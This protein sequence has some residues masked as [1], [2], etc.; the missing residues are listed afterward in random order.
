VKVVLDTN[1]VVSA[2]LS[3]AGKPAAILQLVLHSNFNI[4]FN[5]AILVEYEQVLYR[6][7]F[8]GRIHQ[9]DIERFFELVHDFGVKIIT[10]PSSTC[11]PDESD[12]IFY[13]T[14]KAGDAI[15]ITGN[16][17]HYP[18]EPFIMTPTQ[19]LECL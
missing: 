5:T 1:V 2:F 6:S 13:D 10:K 17:K 11:L 3:P 18:D 19:F 4:C 12:R 16:T 7:K 15:L 14:A 8:A 9:P